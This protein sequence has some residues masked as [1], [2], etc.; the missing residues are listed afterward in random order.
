MHLNERSYTVGEL[1]D[2]LLA[3]FPRER[4]VVISVTDYADPLTVTGYAS[5][6]IIQEIES[7]G[8]PLNGVIWILG[9]RNNPP[10]RYSDVRT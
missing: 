2:A 10:R 7:K 1:A 9:E 5:D 3:N 6:L 4:R 8:H